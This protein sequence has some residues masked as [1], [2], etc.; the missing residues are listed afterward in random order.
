MAVIGLLF[1]IAIVS[2]VV[3]YGPFMRK[4]DFG[5]V[6]TGRSLR[7]R[8]LDMHNLLG[9]VTIVWT[10]VVGATGI[11]NELTIPL[12]KL[13]MKNDVRAMLAPFRDPRSRISPSSVRRRPR[14][15]RCRRR[16][17]GGRSSV[18]FSPALS[19]DR[20]FTISIWTKG[21]EPLTSRLFAPMLVEGKSGTPGGIVTMPWYLTALQVSRPL[22]FGNYGGLPLK[23]IWAL[24]DLVTIMILGS[25]LY[26]W[27]SRRSSSP[28]AA[29]AELIESCATS[30][31]AE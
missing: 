3:I 26:L 11:M 16:C 8:W 23:I 13:W 10:L 18:S 31:V 25:G 12:F 29:E 9:V 2:G 21:S 14:W 30:E 6:R 1:L 4:Q 24:L 20:R 28:A 27:L 15:R 17:R 5:S 22:H 7:L 19:S